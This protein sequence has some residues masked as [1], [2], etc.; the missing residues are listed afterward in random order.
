MKRSAKALAKE[1]KQLRDDNRRLKMANVGEARMRE[2]RQRLVEFE[3][4]PDVLNA[5]DLVQFE[6]NQWPTLI[7]L[8][9][10]KVVVSVDSL[11][12]MLRRGPDPGQPGPPD[13][14]EKV[15]G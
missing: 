5:D 15:E 14:G 12:D 4:S 8:A 3:I 11:E 10:G 6:P 13:D 9:G 2:A 7:R 1:N